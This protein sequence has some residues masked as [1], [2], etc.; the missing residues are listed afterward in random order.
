MERAAI[1]VRADVGI[2]EDHAPRESHACAVTLTTETIRFRR[3]DQSPTDEALTA[4]SMRERSA[5]L[6]RTF[7]SNVIR[8]AQRLAGSLLFA[9]VLFTAA[10][11]PTALAAQTDNRLAVGVSVTTRIAGSSQTETSSDIGIDVRLGHQHE[12]WGWANSFFSW[13]DTEVAGQPTTAAATLGNLRTRPVMA[14]YG[15]TKIWG[16]YAVTTDLIGGYSF[17][18]FHLDPAAVADYQRRGAAVLET[19]TSNTLVVK[20]EV[21]VWYD[22]SPRFGIKAS[23]GYLI[24]RPTVTI[25]TTLGQDSRPVRADTFLVTFSL[26]YSIF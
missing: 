5:A 17:N 8:S 6:D 12:E 19:H 18:S 2:L 15:Y 16:K 14:G 23:G 1:V 3:L 10:L 4:A 21:L 20:P 9:T 7:Q 26:V 22:L 25:A 11:W 24:S 13:F